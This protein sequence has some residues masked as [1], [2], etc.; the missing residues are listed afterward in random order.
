MSSASTSA[1]RR[2]T[3]STRARARSS[4]WGSASWW[5]RWSPPA[6]CARR[7]TSPTR[8]ARRTISLICVG[9]PSRP[10]GEHR[11]A[12]HRARVRARSAPTLKAHRSLAHGGDPQHGAARHDGR[13]RDPG[14]RARLGE[15]VRARTSAS[16]ATPSS[17]AR[18]RRSRTSTRRP[19]TLI[20]TRR[21]ARAREAVRALYAGIDAPLHVTS[22]GVGGDGE[23]RLQRLPRREGR[24][25]PT[26]SAPSARRVGVDSHEVMRIFCEDTKLNISPAYLRPG[27]RVRRLVPAEGRARADLQGAPAGRRRADARRGA[28]EQPEADRARVR[29]GH[30]APARARSACSGWRSRRAPTTCASRPMVTLIEMLIGK[31]M[32]VRV[33]DRDVSSAQPDR[34]QPRVHREGDPAHLD[35]GRRID[36]AR[37]ASGPTSS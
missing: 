31:G 15:E 1:S 25:S 24:R 27:L 28:G 36:G 18:A 5:R 33:F 16:A 32:D 23:V 19:F 12:V 3:C 26:R 37:G 17:C 2:S 6:G 14:A 22:I 4:R 35:A 29:D 7:R 8:C 21:A 11:P 30:R 20:G 34:L 9:T 13:R 10:N